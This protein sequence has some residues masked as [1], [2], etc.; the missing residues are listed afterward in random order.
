L[1]I[2]KNTTGLPKAVLGLVLGLKVVGAI[3]GPV[4]LGGRYGVYRA[5]EINEGFVRALGQVDNRIR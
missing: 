1:T 5:V 2:D 3:A 4:E